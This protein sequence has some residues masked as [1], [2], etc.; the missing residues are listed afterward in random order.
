[1]LR[2]LTAQCSATEGNAVNRHVMPRMMLR[3]NGD[4]S[5]WIVLY[6]KWEEAEHDTDYLLSLYSRL[7]Q[8]V[9]NGFNRLK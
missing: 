5:T 9:F 1:M 3:E 7:T 6:Y 2:G 4:G 8:N